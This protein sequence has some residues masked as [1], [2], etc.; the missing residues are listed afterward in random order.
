MRS[1]RLK[2]KGRAAVYHCM[3]RT[4]NSELLFGPAEKEVLR[5]MIWQVA[6]FCGVE[7][8]TYCVMGNHFHVLLLVPEEQRVEDVELVRR[9]RV[10]YPWATKYQAASAA[11]L[12]QSLLAGGEAAE[13]IRLRLLARM[14]DVSQYMKSVKQRFCVWFNATHQRHGTL[15]ADRFKSVLVE[16]VGNTLQTMA[17]YIDLNP[18]RAGLVDDPKDYRFCGYSEAVVG[19]ERARRGLSVVWRAYGGEGVSQMQAY[20]LALQAHRKLIFGKGVSPSEHAGARIDREAAL[21]VLSRQDGQ[22]PKS[23]LLRLRV[24][25]FSEGAILGSSEFVRGFLEDWQEIRGR[26]HRP[27]VNRLRGGDWGDELSVIQGLRLNAFE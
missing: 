24:R 19:H 11:V 21:A 7:V 9:Y 12:E 14:G 16:G 2:L 13:R 1:R 15:W 23:T 3:T 4:V 26:K 25:Y 22:L 17:V 6:D 27:R 5:K 8:L 10:L 20:Q 18:V